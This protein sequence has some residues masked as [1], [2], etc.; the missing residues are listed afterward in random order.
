MTTKIDP[1]APDLY[2][3]SPG[4]LQAADNHNWGN[5][6]TSWLEPETYV[7]KLGNAGKFIA[8]SVLSGAN[9]FYQT[10]VAVAKWVGADVSADSTENFISSIDS[11]LGQYY[12]ANKDAVDTVGF[13]LGAIVPGLGGVKI[14]N[15]GQKALQTA[16]NTGFLGGNLGKATGLL[17]PNV[18]KY[19]ALA[20][21]EINASLNTTKLLN[22]NTLRAVGAGFWQNTLEAAAFETMVHATMFKSPLLEQQD[23]GDIVTNVA[24]GGLVGG[25]IGSAF[26]T[27]GLI[28]KIKKAV[29]E[30]KLARM[31]FIERPQF[32]EATTPSEKIAALA[33]DSETSAVPVVLRNA[34]GTVVEN[35]FA[36]NKT[37]YDDKLRKNFNEIRTEIHKLIPGGDDE[38][39]NLLANASSP[40]YDAATQTYKPGY[41]QGY[42][43][44]FSGAIELGRAGVITR[45]ESAAAKAAKTGEIV[46]DIAVRYTKILGEGVGE[47][48]DSA[49]ILLSIADTVTSQEAAL[50][51]VK[52]FGFNLKSGTLWDAS[53]L[54]GATAHTQAEARQIWATHVLKEIPDNTLIHE[55]DL[56]LLER[57]YLDDKFASIKISRGEGP[58][59]EV[60]TPGSQQELYDIIKESKLEVANRL[61][62]RM[63][64]DGSVPIEQ[65]T[66]AA[67]KI[68]NTRLAFLEGTPSAS[69]FSDLFAHQ[70]DALKH[71][72]DLKA[73]NLTTAG[74]KVVDPQFLPKYSKI[75]YRIDKNVKDVNGNIADAMTFYRAQQKIYEQSAKVVAAK[76]LGQGA[77]DLPDITTKMTA[78][79]D[80]TTAGPGFVSF[81]NSNYGTW[82][83]TLQWIGS[84]VRGFKEAARKQTSEALES[85]LVRLGAN[86]DAAFEFESINQKVSRSGKLWVQHTEDG[87]TYLVT[88]ESK[89][90]LQGTAD[91]A[92]V[93]VRELD[94]SAY[95]QINN[96]ETA[97]AISAHISTSGKRT[98]SFRDI[99][100]AQGKEDL[101]DPEVFRPIRPDLKRYQHFAFIKDDSVTGAGHITMIHAAS[102]RELNGLLD[103]VPARY[104]KL[105]KTD[106]EE[107]KRARQEY[108]FSRTL[109]ENY[110]DSEMAAKGVFS[111]FFPKS[112]PAKIVD[113]ILQQ[114]LRESDVLVTETV[115]LRYEPQFNLLEDLG[116]Q[117]S[118]AAT[119]KFASRAEL[120]E[121]T[122]DNPY[123]NHIKTALDIS[124][125]SE[126]NL[127]YSF[128][129]LLDEGVS[130]LNARLFEQFRGIKSPEELE[131]INATLDKHGMKPAY[132]DSALQALANHTAPRGVLTNFVRKANSL[133]SLFTLG[134]DPLNSINNAVGAN[135][136]RMT[137]LK[138]LTEAIKGG[139]TEIAGE[140][141]KL[142][143]IRLPGTGD[144][145]LAP[146]KLVANAVRNFWTD[147][148][149]LLARYKA[150]GIIKDRVEQL[151]MLVDDF[152]LQGTETVAELNQ[153]LSKGFERAKN[154]AERGETL[155]G[156]KL[157]EEFNRF[158]SANVMEQITNI[159]TKYGLLDSATAKAYINTF[160]NRVE[161]TIVAS[162]RPLVFQGPIGQAIGLFQS[163]QFNLLQQLFRYVA[164]GSKKDIAVMLGLQST[165]YGIQSLP[166]FQFINTHIIGQLSG[167]KEHRD[168]YDA[169]YGTVGRTAGDFVLYGIPSNILNTNIYSR[170][171]I[172][173]RQITILPTSL[174]EIPLV[175]GWGKFLTNMK[176][177][178]GKIQGGGAIW[179]SMLQGMEHNGVSRPLAGFAQTLRGLGDGQVTSTQ[180][181]GNI[182]YQNDLYSWATI[183]RL[184][185]GRPL[186]EAI[187][188]DALF[189][190]KTYDAAR[191]KDMAS[192]SE[193]VKT[194]LLQGGEVSQESINQFAEKYVELGGKQSGFNKW[195]INLYKD[196]NTSQA[197]QLRASLSNPF[198][199]KM[200]TLM[201]GEDE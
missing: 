124:T 84:Q 17:A 55:F 118:K 134:L 32:A 83:S 106:V 3:A 35:N 63:S 14:L 88:K 10:G 184:A 113:D 54:S 99:R 51:R 57:A 129:K 31:P 87:V 137:E 86:T 148:G 142:A 25:V 46:P 67:A 89:A 61:L 168:L 60:F 198:A 164:E 165:L 48:S 70:S 180:N 185:G 154:L 29:G 158:V 120:I 135:I 122:T 105:L 150:E 24:V 50:K 56:P 64:L 199:Y 136:L 44:S 40:F 28:G 146:T 78:A 22:A 196:T 183:V 42:L 197:E 131:Q 58:T 62:Q 143:K 144:E 178:V 114:H 65:G 162:Q 74:K 187:T 127:M 191:R 101:K 156:N 81:A 93:S 159:G 126:S 45:A 69:E 43:E 94:S 181:N 23:F 76:I 201:G 109:H 115:R 103:K 4:Y 179:E 167:N 190:V 139:N 116:R 19:V 16:K 195:M 163:Y 130:R 26:T 125:L 15:A 49:P 117:Y 1:A 21:G 107:F 200:Q 188:N 133:L 98:N 175:Q 80:H 160:V 41:A 39:G 7:N 132:Y 149:T 186:D 30:E 104:T 92:P 123:F 172:N 9:S 169:T 91:I 95:I 102:E 38:L 59:L 161:G 85:A 166:A 173:P 52:E 111:N 68:A 110:L 12:R 97:D 37:L 73:K 157:A 192:L 82:G 8:A 100:A 47:V 2:S 194:H 27:P 75:V 11:D 151:K 141:G 33:W 155:S 96:P 6:G 182:L 153:R 71:I 72:E 5:T 119:S 13:V 189:R 79:M 128:N 112:D 145:I 171:D 170:G 140:L 18:E 34:D 53:K 174:Q 77:E 147:D 108:E 90:A 193:K 20:A 176:E 138:H 177:T 66:A 152:T 121:K 36:V